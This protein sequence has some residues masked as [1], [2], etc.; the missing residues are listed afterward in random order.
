MSQ[1]IRARPVIAVNDNGGRTLPAKPIEVK[2]TPW[3]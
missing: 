2:V 3:R 1:I